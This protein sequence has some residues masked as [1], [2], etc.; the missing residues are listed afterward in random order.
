MNGIQ[1]GEFIPLA[2]IKC[3]HEK[4]A[5]LHSIRE[6]RLIQ[7]NDS[8]TR[9]EVVC[10]NIPES[11]TGLDLDVTGYHRGCY[12][13]FTKNL[14]RLKCGLPDDQLSTP[15]SPRKLPSISTRTHFPPACIF[16]DK[17]EKKVSWK[18]ERCIKFS[19]VKGKVPAWKQVEP[20]ALQ[21]GDRRLH[22]K[23]VGE[24]LFARRACFH[25]SCHNSFNL[26]YRNHLRDKDHMKDP[27]GAAHQMLTLL[28]HP[29]PFIHEV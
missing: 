20:R 14:D 8:A 7:P 25:K 18:T 16:C 13:K 28:P 19:F 12:Q 29:E 9:M 17:V 2:N 21:M 5:K 23:V 22:R 24:D 15:R 10:N 3:S 1:H 27:K 4:L 6:K 26:R 11:L